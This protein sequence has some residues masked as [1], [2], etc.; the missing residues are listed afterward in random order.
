M[1]MEI[2]AITISS[3][4][5]EPWT[6]TSGGGA[7]PPSPP[8]P[9]A[10]DL[11]HGKIVFLQRESIEALNGTNW[12]HTKLVDYVL[13]KCIRGH[14]PATSMPQDNIIIASSC[15]KNWFHA[16][17]CPPTTESTVPPKKKEQKSQRVRQNR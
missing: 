8:R 1:E 11:L 16:M 5:D 2:D 12:L 14:L 17:N 4:E 3:S 9:L 15:S 10:E 6:T 7:S 13:Q